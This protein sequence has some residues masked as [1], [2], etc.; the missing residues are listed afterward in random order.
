MNSDSIISTYSYSLKKFMAGISKASSSME[1][2]DVSAAAVGSATGGAIGGK[3]RASTTNSLGGGTVSD[4]GNM[5][6]FKTYAKT[7]LI[8]AA[9]H[10]VASQM[11]VGNVDYL[12]KV[13]IGSETTQR[14][15]NQRHTSLH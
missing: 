8:D 6:K 9:S 3:I 13:K 14:I 10:G 7:G 4:I 15:T 12:M 11:D 1:D 5:D 2:T